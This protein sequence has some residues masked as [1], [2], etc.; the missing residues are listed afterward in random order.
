[1]RTWRSCAR[2]FDTPRVHLASFALNW[3]FF[4]PGMLRQAQ[5]ETTSRMLCNNLSPVVEGC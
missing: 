5:D 1:M 3:Q 2:V 4:L